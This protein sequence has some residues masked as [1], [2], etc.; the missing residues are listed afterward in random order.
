MNKEQLRMQMLAGIIT[1]GQYK[2]ILNEGIYLLFNKSDGK[3][4]NTMKTPDSKENDTLKK[5]IEDKGEYELVWSTDPKFINFQNVK[6]KTREEL[7]L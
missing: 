4:K 6:G 7:G 3:L 1:E 2:E 5:Q